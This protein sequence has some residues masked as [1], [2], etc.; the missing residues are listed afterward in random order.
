MERIAEIQNCEKMLLQ[1]IKEN[2]INL[3]DKLLHRDLLFVNPMGQII[4]K[5]M[6][7]ANYTSG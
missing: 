6:D 7:M 2:N 4:T 1:A 5:T 3:L